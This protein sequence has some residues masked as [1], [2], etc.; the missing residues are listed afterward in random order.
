MRDQNAVIT[1]Q[2]KFFICNS[3][4]AKHLYNYTITQLT[5][6]EFPD[7]FRIQLKSLE[8]SLEPG[9]IFQRKSPNGNSTKTDFSVC[10]D[11]TSISSSR[12][13][14]SSDF[15]IHCRKSDKTKLVLP[16]RHHNKSKYC[17][18]FRRP[19]IIAT[20]CLLIATATVIAFITL[21]GK[22]TQ[23]H[24]FQT[25]S[26]HTFDSP[27]LPTALIAQS[28]EDFHN[29]GQKDTIIIQN[30]GDNL[31]TPFP[32]LSANDTKYITT[33]EVSGAVSEAWLLFLLQSFDNVVN[34]TIDTACVSVRSGSE[35]LKSI[36]SSSLRHEN[37]LRLEIENLNRSSVAKLLFQW[38][39]VILETLLIRIA[40]LDQV[41]FRELKG[42]LEKS[43]VS[44]EE[45]RIF[46]SVMCTD[47]NITELDNVG[48]FNFIVHDT[49]NDILLSS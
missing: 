7:N 45:V 5:T 16:D 13:S 11:E 30:L 39:F 28:P 40:H 26:G 24:Q 23:A 1:I 19:R 12:S 47:C 49:Q 31:E 32:L 3:L 34:L 44:L 46:D 38:D 36:I 42:F 21:L 33:M 18:I 4:P 22:S 48:H 14:S 29:L 10:R 37:V 15:R 25:F 41:L 43:K 17:K 2:D 20:I 8:D 9:V 27:L 35:G 6:M